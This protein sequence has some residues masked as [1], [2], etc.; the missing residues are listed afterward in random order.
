MIPIV[1][2]MNSVYDTAGASVFADLNFFQKKLLPSYGEITLNN[3]HENSTSPSFEN[4]TDTVSLPNDIFKFFPQEL[5]RIDSTRNFTLRLYPKNDYFQPLSSSDQNST[6]KLHFDLFIREQ[7]LTYRTSAM[8]LLKWFW[9][10]YF[11]IFVMV[12]LFLR[13]LSAFL[14]ESQVLPTLV[15]NGKD[16]KN[17]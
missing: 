11:S 15:F 7:V 16:N 9:L 14:Y 10:Q 2:Y 5:L 6:F 4:E 8:E 13:V 3:F 1:G 17:D 12:K